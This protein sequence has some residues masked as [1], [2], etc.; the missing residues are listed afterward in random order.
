MP[1]FT[2][3]FDRL[4]LP[5]CY[6]KKIEK[7]NLY[8]VSILWRSTVGCAIF[9]TMWISYRDGLRPLYSLKPKG[10]HLQCQTVMRGIPPSKSLLTLS[11]RGLLYARFSR[12]WTRS[13]QLCPTHQI[14]WSCPPL[15][16][17]LVKC[18]GGCQSFPKFLFI[19]IHPPPPPA[20]TEICLF[21]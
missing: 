7:P 5:Y 3:L 15:K 16:L 12:H 17:S 18:R 4:L 21:S 19:W 13:Q 11:L 2:D 1:C 14:T 6:K 10:Q 9:H 20:C 8:N